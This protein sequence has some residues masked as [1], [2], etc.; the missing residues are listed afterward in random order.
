MYVFELQLTR[1][2]YFMEPYMLILYKWVVYHRY[3]V[4]Y[5]HVIALPVVA[6]KRLLFDS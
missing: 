2:V 4:P 1:I 5:D 3:L 6:I